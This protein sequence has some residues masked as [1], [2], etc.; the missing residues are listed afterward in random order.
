VSITVDDIGKIVIC[1]K[2]G[3]KGFL[4]VKTAGA[5]GRKYRYFVVRHVDGRTHYVRK[6]TEEEARFSGL[7]NSAKREESSSLAYNAKRLANSAKPEESLAGE[8]PSEDAL[9]LVYALVEYLKAQD[10]LRAFLR[11]E[12]P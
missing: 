3:V 1:P 6:L 2:C 9:R 4:E 5:K 11:G 12:E 8:K 10:R 7:A